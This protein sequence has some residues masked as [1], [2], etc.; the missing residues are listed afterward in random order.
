M[1]EIIQASPLITTDRASV[2]P[3]KRPFL[4]SFG[5]WAALAIV[6]TILISLGFRY[7]AQSFF[8][9]CITFLEVVL[10]FNILII[11]HEL[12]HFLA[13]R[14][15]GLKVEKFAIWMGKAIW[16]KKID[17]VE[18]ILGS[19]PAGGYVALPQMAPMEAIE[20]KT[21]T[22]K[23]DLP[24]ASPWH[25]TIVAFAGPL[26]S[27]GLAVVFAC[28]VWVVGKPV[29]YTETTTVI[30]YVDPTGPAAKAGLQP[31]DRIL[32][33]DGHHVSRFIGI[34]DAINWR[35]IT[36]TAP[37]IA[38]EVE[39]NGVNQTF[40]V[41]PVQQEHSFWERATPRLVRIGPADKALIVKEVLPNSPAVVAGIVPGDQFLELDGKKLYSSAMV[42]KYVE[43]HGTAPMNVKILH[44]GVE[45]E[46]TVK[47]E[48]PVS[49]KG[50][51]DAYLG[52]GWDIAVELAH[53]SPSEQVIGSAEMVVSTLGALF[54]SHSNVSASQLSGPIG[55]MNIFF[56]VLSSP[57]G[58]RLA[59][60][61][62]V[63]INV[64]LA[65]LNL[66]P[67]PVLDGGHIALSVIEWIRRRPLSMSILE[68]L[69][70]ACALLLI[71]YML[72]ITFFDI[73]DS[74]RIA[75]NAGGGE[76]KF[77]PK[78]GSQ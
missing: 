50:V 15:C 46:V 74:G 73:Q 54:A 58:W 20:G 60:W 5:F 27:F 51:K 12:G 21:D 2:L 9:S 29:T 16:S 11:V 13:A 39:R 31:G 8:F 53:P 44:Q 49:P 59:L 14:W 67:L 65:L 38:I 24:P 45:R 1:A 40:Q 19:I 35:I 76:I 61:L 63:V 41:N 64:N 4:H 18:Y 48:I 75:M 3:P 77:A 57:D 56:A 26:F 70:T 42:E 28:I 25:K 36:S 72:F 69:Q 30:G 37:S 71:G 17:G 10:L 68:P 32:S 43:D 52:I 66:F 55:I 7:G 78:S 47:P 34:G 23:E 22:P 62:A 6:L 33:V